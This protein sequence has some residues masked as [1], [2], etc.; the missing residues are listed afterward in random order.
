MTQWCPVQNFQRFRGQ[1]NESRDIP[2][3]SFLKIGLDNKTVRPA[4]T[5]SILYQ[6][7][8]ILQDPYTSQ[9]IFVPSA[10]AG[11][12]VVSGFPPGCITSCHFTNI[13]TWSHENYLRPTTEFPNRASTQRR[14]LLPASNP[15]YQEAKK[16]RIGHTLFWNACADIR[17]T[18]HAAAI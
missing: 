15:V 7:T 2:W 1:N 8:Y 3:F 18:S 5:K 10:L 4:V 11:G 6:T 12:M 16:S 9:S 17:L 13:H 14:G